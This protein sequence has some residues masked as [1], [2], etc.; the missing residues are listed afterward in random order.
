VNSQLQK[1]L[2]N[3]HIA[4]SYLIID[5]CTENLLAT[6]RSFASHFNPADVF[7]LGNEQAPHIQVKETLDFMQT[8]HLAP[9]GDR[10]LFIICDAAT[11]TTAAQNKTLKTIED[12]PAQT[13]FMLLATSIEPI[14]NTIRSR[15]VTLYAT[16]RGGVGGNAPLSVDTA[17]AQLLNIKIEHNF[18]T[19]NT[20]A[21]INRH[22]AAN[23]NPQNQQDLLLI[24]LLKR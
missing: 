12:A 13:T 21:E 14:L 15:C 16:P 2:D 7:F 9:V 5:P 24:E 4:A 3:G 10:K 8:A 22:I 6:A 18:T 20:L 17:A 23:C 11:M 19:H 1:H